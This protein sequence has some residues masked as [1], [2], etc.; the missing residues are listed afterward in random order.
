MNQ[1]DTFRKSL[2]LL[3][4]LLPF[5]VMGDWLYQNYD[6]AM[7]KSKDLISRSQHVIVYTIFIFIGLCMLLQEIPPWWVIPA[8]AIPHWLIDSYKPVYWWCKLIQVD[9]NC[10][11]EETFINSFQKPRQVIM[12][13]VV[14]QMLHFLTLIPVL[15]YLVK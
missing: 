12:Y 11:T 7:S 14:D 10:E 6:I 8:I 5:H 9:P 15:D 2:E 3:I 13:I 4:L 1:L